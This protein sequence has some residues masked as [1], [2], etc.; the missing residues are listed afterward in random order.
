MLIDETGNLTKK[1]TDELIFKDGADFLQVDVR[2]KKIC[3]QCLLTYFSSANLRAL[4]QAS[5][6]E[7]F[8]VGFDFFVLLQK[9]QRFGLI[10]QLN[11]KLKIIPEGYPQQ[12]KKL[13]ISVY[14][15][16]DTIYGS[17][18]L[19]IKHK[20]TN[21]L[22]CNFFTQNGMHK[23]RVKNWKKAA[24]QLPIANLIIGSEMLISPSA[25]LPASE[26]GLQKHFRKVLERLQPDQ[27]TKIVLSPWNP[28]RLYHFNEIANGYDITI[29]WQPSFSHLLHYF[30]PHETFTTTKIK[31]RP[32]KMIFQADLAK[33]KKG[34]TFSYTDQALQ[35][36]LML[37]KNYSWTDKNNFNRLGSP[38]N[39]ELCRR[40]KLELQPQRFI[41]FPVKNVSEGID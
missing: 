35:N 6:C 5:P 18:S 39:K 30:Y 23:K 14:K 20:K 3:R 22:Y 28:E 24:K 27:M 34:Q 38:E 36:N 26:V 8:Y 41:F 12:F 11:A 21:T 15:N 1:N 9:M 7:I 4:Y 32:E 10:P 16:D 25:Q 31:K 13:Q 17:L 33:S 19:I 2:K 40:L 29:I 37:W